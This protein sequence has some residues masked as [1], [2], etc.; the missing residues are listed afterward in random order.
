[1]GSRRIPGIGLDGCPLLTG[2]STA[3]RRRLRRPLPPL[4]A[5][6]GCSRRLTSRAISAEATV[7]PRWFSTSTCQTARPHRG[8]STGR[9]RLRRQRPRIVSPGR[10]GLRKRQVIPTRPTVAGSGT[11]IAPRPAVTAAIRVPGTTG[12][13]KGPVRACS[14][15]VK[16]GLYSPE[17]LTK[18]DRSAGVMV[19]RR[20]VHSPPSGRSSK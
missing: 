9:L 10:T 20:V 11:S 8:L 1:M 2:A 17:T 13:P 15:S 16:S 14:A 7:S 18:A 3:A 4:A 12:S 19:L 6:T 5:S